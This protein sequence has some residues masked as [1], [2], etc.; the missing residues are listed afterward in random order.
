MGD[1]TKK[2]KK[3]QKKS[4][5]KFVVECDLKNLKKKFV[6]DKENKLFVVKENHKNLY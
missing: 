5:A 4:V 1:Y 2:V 3:S 6:T